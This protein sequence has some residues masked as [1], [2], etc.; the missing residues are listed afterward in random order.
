MPGFDLDLQKAGTIPGAGRIEVG[1]WDVSGG[2]DTVEVPTRLVECYFGFGI[3]AYDYTAGGFSAGYTPSLVFTSDC[4]IT[5]SAITVRR[6]GTDNTR[7][8]RFRYI[9]VG[10]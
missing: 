10:W 1:Y 3:A 9:F 2:S 7:D 6:M 4:S 5:L 8:E